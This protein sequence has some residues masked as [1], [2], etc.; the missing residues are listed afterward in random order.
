MLLPSIRKMSFIIF[1]ATI[2]LLG[3]GYFMQYQLGLEPCPLCVT[4]RIF[5][6][7][8][9]LLSLIAFLHSPG[10]IGMRIYSVLISFSAVV[11]GGF[12]MRQLYLQSLPAD[13]APACGPTLAY[14][15]DAFPFM[16]AVELMLKGDGNC[17]EV[18]WTFMGLSIP[19][20]TL[21]AF[22]MLTLAGVSQL[23]RCH[24]ING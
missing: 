10:Y 4:Q 15:F 13:L 21:V 1:I 2:A 19:G 24:K 23:L 7:L 8:T 14:M 18:V 6:A 11:G 20:W 22:A 5:I 9:G 3:V 16:K 12:S 17:A